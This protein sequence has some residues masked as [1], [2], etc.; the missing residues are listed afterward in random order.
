MK[1]I[2][3]KYMGKHKMWLSSILNISSPFYT[4]PMTI[5]VLLLTCVVYLLLKLYP[6]SY[7]VLDTK[8]SFGVFLY[9]KISVS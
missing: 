6:Q 5:S 9:Q 7:K 3:L 1:R 4:V 8:N 2:C